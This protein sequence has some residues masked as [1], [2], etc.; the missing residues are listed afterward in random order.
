MRR[1]FLPP[2]LAATA[3]IDADLRGNQAGRLIV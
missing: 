2:L 1:R 3:A